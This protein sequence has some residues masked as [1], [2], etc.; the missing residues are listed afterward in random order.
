[1]KVSLI[2]PAHNEEKTIA[3]TLRSVFNQ[4]KVPDEIIIIEDS[5]TDKTFSVLKKFQEK[6]NGIKI[7]RV[8]NR[9]ISKNRNI[10]IRKS[11]NNFV[12][13]I[14]AGCILERDYVKKIS[15]PFKDKKIKFVGAISRLLTKTLFD[16]CFSCF[17]VKKNVPNG[18]IPKG[19]AMAFTKGVWEEVGGFPE[20]LALGAED[21][22][23]GKALI[24]M[25]HSPFIVKD[26]IIYW[27][28]RNNMKTIY[29][30]FM[31]YGYWDAKAFSPFKLPKNSK[32]AIIVAIIFPFAIIHSILKGVQLFLNFKQYRAFFYGVGIDLAKIYG[33]VFGIIKGVSANNGKT[34]LLSM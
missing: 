18:Y 14:D 11:K 7:V 28:T 9:N 34:N 21:T 13:C 15:D 26:A 1:M 20:H 2:C 27:E 12:I 32:F 33:Y 30:Q 29:K 3:K 24:K 31:S 17:V 4:S 8:K 19:H 22:F 23:F 16:K 5:S 6:H 10:A 25:G